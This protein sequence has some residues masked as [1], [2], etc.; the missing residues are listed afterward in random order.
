[1]RRGTAVSAVFAGHSVAVDPE[2]GQQ[3]REVGQV[4]VSV[5]LCGFDIAFVARRAGLRAEVRQQN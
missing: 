3:Q 2:I 4:H 5:A 1:L